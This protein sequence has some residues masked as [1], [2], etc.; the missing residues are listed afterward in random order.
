MSRS[1]LPEERLEILRRLDP[2]R[3]WHAL[4]D[5]RACAVCDRV[6]TGRQVEI[7]PA[8]RGAY[9][10]HCPTPGCPSTIRH[11]FLRGISGASRETPTARRAA[12]LHLF[13]HPR[14][15]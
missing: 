3:K 15:A 2:E 5:K 7:V 9:S 6:F 14:H 10:L 8:A 11:W 4:D 1:L 13:H 12:Q